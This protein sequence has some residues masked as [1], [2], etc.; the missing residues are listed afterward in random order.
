MDTFVKKIRIAIEYGEKF[1]IVPNIDKDWS[2]KEIRF[3]YT[4]QDNSIELRG[5]L[6]KYNTQEGKKIQVGSGKTPTFFLSDEVGKSPFRSVYEAVE[7]ALLTDY[8][9]LRCAPM[10]TLT[11]GEAEK[12]KDAENLIRF[13]NTER[14]F[15]MSL[16]ES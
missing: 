6:Y 12:A 9:N 8:G 2:K 4:K 7:P 13:P 15:T 10:F 16:D 1:I 5:T 11:G 3:G 14:Q